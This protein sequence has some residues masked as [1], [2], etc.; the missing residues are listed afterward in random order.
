METFEFAS[1]VDVRGAVRLLGS[2]WGETEILAGGTDLIS[3]MKDR[4]TTPKRLVSLKKVKGL[5]HIEYSCSPSSNFW[6]ISTLSSITPPSSRLPTAFAASRCAIWERSAGNY[7]NGPGGGIS[8]T[9]S[10]CWPNTKGNP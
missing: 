6:I 7:S 10:G 1:P 5:G 4:I 3:A 2:A 8:A 9:D